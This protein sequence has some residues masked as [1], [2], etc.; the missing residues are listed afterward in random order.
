M[1]RINWTGVSDSPCSYGNWSGFTHKFRLELHGPDAVD[2]AVDVVVAFHQADVFD[3]R[4]HLHHRRGA[5]DLEVFDHADRVA[6]GEKVA[7]G[8]AHDNAGFRH[9]GR[10]GARRPLVGAVRTDEQI[11]VFISVFT[12]AFWA[13]GQLAHGRKGVQDGKPARSEHRWQAPTG[14]FSGGDFRI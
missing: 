1:S 2:F 4:A 8:V 10:A 6:V 7:V 11:A 5:F 13:V 9:I 12:V 3:L 14:A